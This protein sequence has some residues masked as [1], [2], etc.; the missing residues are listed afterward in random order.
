MSTSVRTTRCWLSPNPSSM[1]KALVGIPYHIAFIFDGGHI[2]CWANND[3]FVHAEVRALATL[4][5][6]VRSDS[7]LHRLSM[8]VV[9]VRRNDQGNLYFSMSKPCDR[10]CNCI[11]NSSLGKLYWSTDD[12]FSWSY[13]NDVSSC[14]LSRR[15]R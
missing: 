1:Q 6:R 13:T 5:R 2:V 4:R 10:C 7:K 3:R 15:Y 9:R 11:R 8:V 14:H 12:G